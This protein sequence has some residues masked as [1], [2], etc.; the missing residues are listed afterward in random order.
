MDNQRQF[1]RVQSLIPIQVE[2]V[3]RDPSDNTKCSVS[4]MGLPNQASFK[5][6][7]IQSN[8]PAMDPAL[9][10]INK[11]LDLIIQLLSERE[12]GKQEFTSTPVTLSATGMGFKWKETFEAESLL[13]IKIKRQSMARQCVYT[14]YGDV[15]RCLTKEEGRHDI[16]VHFV[17]LDQWM[18]NELAGFILNLERGI[19]GAKI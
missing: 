17:G 19:E 18:E 8:D 1:Y 3:T 5:S 11:K 9:N 10:I 15:I 14:L 12:A 13:R 6:T 16:A 4:D 2:L 7:S